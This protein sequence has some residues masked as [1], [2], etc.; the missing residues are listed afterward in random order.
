[1]ETGAHAAAD[2]E[3]RN[4]LVER[5]DLAHP[6][7]AEGVVVFIAPGSADR[8]RLGQVGFEAEVERVGLLTPFPGGLRAGPGIAAGAHALGLGRAS[9]GVNA[10]RGHRIEWLGNGIGPCAIGLLVARGLGVDFLAVFGAGR[11]GQRGGQT[12]IER[13]GEVGVEVQFLLDQVAE[14]E[15]RLGFG[16]VGK[17]G[18]IVHRE[19]KGVARPRTREIVGEV[20]GMALVAQ[21]AVDFLGLAHE[22]RGET[23][24]IERAKAE[25]VAILHET[26]GR[27]RGIPGRTGRE[28]ED[29]VEGAVGPL[30]AHDAA[31]IGGGAADRGAI[32]EALVA[33][34]AGIVAEEIDLA[35]VGDI[36]RGVD[37]RL[38]AVAGRAA[39]VLHRIGIVGQL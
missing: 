26:A 23:G 22:A 39:P 10:R 33:A 13:I 5:V 14:L 3:T 17:V 36:E 8:Q 21:D 9:G 34:A 20:A 2:R 7:I 19:R 16:A 18:R 31:G 11:N 6:G 1:M 15:R 37:H 32:V 38:E 28:V 35:V 29:V 30:V 12:Q 27:A 24:R 25:S 4:D